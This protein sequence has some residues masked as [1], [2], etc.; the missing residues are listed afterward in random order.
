VVDLTQE[1]SAPPVHRLYTDYVESGAR[2]ET[3]TELWGN[4]PATMGEAYKLLE[5]IKKA[6]G[7][8]PDEL[9]DLKKAMKANMR[10]LGVLTSK[11]SENI[12]RLD[13]GAIETGQ[14]PYALGGSSLILNKIAYINS[15]S[16]L[17]GE[18]YAPLFFVADYDG[19]QA[20]LLNTRVPSP[21][22]RGLLFSYPAGPEYE[23]API[24][25]LPNPP[26]PWLDKALEN[27]RGNYRGL[28][29]DA[30]PHVRDMEFLNLEH[31]ITILKGAFYSTENVSD[32]STKVV[33]TLVNLES[34]LGTPILPFSMPGSRRLFQSGYEFLL[35]DVN[36]ERFIEATNR[37]AEL[38]EASGHRAGIGVRKPEYVPFFLECRASRC[39]GSRVELK[40]SREAGS[41]TASVS[42]KC[43]RCGEA[44]E[45]TF[46]AGSPDLTDIVESI[47][48][49]VDSRQIVVDS[50]VPM[51]A[52]VGGP[53]ET[54]YY[55]EVIPA[56][57][58]LNLP[59]PVFVRY[60]RLFYNTPWNDGYARALM[61]RGCCCLTDGGLFEALSSW[62]DARNSSDPDGLRDA[63]VAIRG[64]IEATARMLE[65]ILSKLRAE[66]EDIKGRLGNP[67][68]RQILIQE[69]RR[70]QA[71][72]QEIEL[73]MS[74]A[75]G[76]FSPE[77]F[78]QEVSWAWLDIATV[79]GVG[80]LMGVFLRQY[81]ENTPNSSMFYANL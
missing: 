36:R 27:L 25:E 28:L 42:G 22:S 65:D 37:A 68:D 4:I 59:F 79:A 40:Y 41:A 43:P 1:E 11:A 31:A 61:S 64:C 2:G 66:I 78:G 52:H 23:N 72:A 17:G 33:G 81:S 62:V 70:K 18:G 35:S 77:R 80:D 55:A 44:Y 46:D 67:G 47:S 74:S 32:W 58:A 57:R 34:D 49:R 3:A 26:E 14:Q 5:G 60:T 69:M 30:D 13:R 63:H 7:P 56:A 8:V 50:V 20:E 73:Y 10:R 15:L 9:E 21:S 29:R 75:L 71:Q 39:N 53:G 76:R 24:Y 12:D 19:V 38:V 16:G 45:F 51:L 6:Y 54:S 48:P